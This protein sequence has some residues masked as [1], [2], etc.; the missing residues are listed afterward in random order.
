MLAQRSRGSRWGALV[1]RDREAD[2]KFYS[3]GP[4]ASAAHR[5]GTASAR[6]RA[7]PPHLGT[8][9]GKASG[10]QALPAGEASPNSA[11]RS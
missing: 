7:I 2:G 6:E 10:L 5:A 11:L 9:S 4:R 8:P 3:V 1:A